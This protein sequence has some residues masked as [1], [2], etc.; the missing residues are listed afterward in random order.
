MGRWGQH[1]GAV[2]S[3]LSPSARLALWYTL[4]IGSLGALHPFLARTLAARGAT[5]GAIAGILTLFPI[6]FLSAGVIWGYLTDRSAHPARWLRG[7]SCVAAVA[8]CLAAWTDSWVVLMVAFALLAFSRAPMV[9]LVDALTVAAL[10]E[11]G[12]GYGRVRMWGSVCFAAMV[13]GVGA[14]IDAVVDSPLVVNALLLSLCALWTFTLPAAPIETRLA[15][16]GELKRLLH[17]KKVAVVIG[18]G[19]LLGVMHATYDFLFS[20]YLE[21]L[22]APTSY[23]TAAFIGGL[24]VEV[25]VMGTSS[26]LLKRL[27]AVGMMRLALWT[28]IPRFLI[29]GAAD[30]VLW[31]VAAQFTHGITFGAFWMG[32]VSWL[33]ENVAPQARNS[34]QS[35]LM[36]TA[37]GLGPL[38]M[39]T[40]ATVVDDVDSLK[41]LFLFASGVAVVATLWFSVTFRAASTED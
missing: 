39:L 19:G 16:L 22:G 8:S 17:Q 27:G 7:A 18:V 23:A 40:G 12:A 26:W 9:P 4:A 32:A 21:G 5:P 13:F 34:A 30:E 20:L 41:T 6:G 33:S 37:A 11:G 25:T 36:A 35:A 29:T 15:G 38:I 24:T 10:G 1:G 31:I 14:Q 3:W 28:A 2:L